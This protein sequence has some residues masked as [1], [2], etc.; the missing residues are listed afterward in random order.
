MKCTSGSMK[1]E[2]LLN[3]QYE[4]IWK[5]IS[6]SKNK[7]AYETKKIRTN[8]NSFCYYVGFSKEGCMHTLLCLHWSQ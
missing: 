4:R 7:E 6:E 3:V 8:I 5:D 1:V 2:K